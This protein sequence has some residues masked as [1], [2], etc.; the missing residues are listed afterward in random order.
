MTHVSYQNTL[1][2]VSWKRNWFS[3]MW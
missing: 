1:L 3:C 2:L